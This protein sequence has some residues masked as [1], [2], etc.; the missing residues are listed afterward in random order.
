MKELVLWVSILFVSNYWAQT[1]P[2]SDGGTVDVV[3]GNPPIVL[4]DAGGDMNYSSGESFEMTFCPDGGNAIV[5]LIDTETNGDVFDITSTDQITIFDGPDSSSPILGS[6]NN[7]NIPGPVITINATLDNP[8][9][10]LTILFFSSASSVTGAGFTSQINCGNFWQPFE[11]EMITSDSEIDD[12]NYV[13]ICQGDTVTF[14][15]NGVFPF[16][17]G[18][19]YNQSNENSFFQWDMGPGQ[20]F[21]GFGLTSV[22]N[23]YDNAFGYPFTLPRA[24]RVHFSATR[25][26]REER[27]SSRR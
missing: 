3:C 4:T 2:I 25:W 19:G 27:G 17:T 15:A 21:E 8:T 11:I 14:N 1:T 18:T 16:S 22:V 9:G 13:D 5:F 7:Q 6:F 10:C 24:G 12:F 23:S 20:T 26:P